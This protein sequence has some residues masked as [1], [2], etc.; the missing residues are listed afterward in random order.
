MGIKWFHQKRKNANERGECD[1]PKQSFIK[2]NLDNIPGTKGHKGYA[3]VVYVV[4]PGSLMIGS[5]RDPEIIEGTAGITSAKVT[6]T[7]ESSEIVI[8][9]THTTN[10]LSFSFD[11]AAFF[12]I[13]RNA[14]LRVRMVIQ[15]IWVKASAASTDYQLLII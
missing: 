6:F 14:S 10:T 7:N 4:N 3:Q 13:P 8:R 11:N 9:N 12:T 5:A 1:M 15:E 2:V